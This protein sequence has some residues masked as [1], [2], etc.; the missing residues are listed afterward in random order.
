MSQSEPSVNLR[1]PRLEKRL[2]PGSLRR[3]TA[4][5]AGPGSGKT[6]L[7]KQCFD[8]RTAVWHTVTTA[9][10]TFSVLAR[11]VIRKLRLVIPGLSPDLVAAIE[12]ARGPDL[13]VDAGRPVAIVSTLAAD[14]D[15]HLDREVILVLDDLHELG[16]GDSAG[17]LDA[18]CRHGPRQIKV[19]TASRTALPFPV[20]R[21]RVAGEVDEI[22]S[23]DLL[24]TSEEVEEL[25]GIRM[26]TH[27]L[28]LGDEINRLTGGWPVA[29]VLAIEAATKN[30]ASLRR[31]LVE[32][33]PLFDYLAE[34]VIWAETPE[35]IEAMRDLALLPWVTP[36]LLDH[37]DIRLDLS[38]LSHSPV[39]VS[40]APDVPGAL[41]VSPLVKEYLLDHYPID[42]AS[43]GHL[44]TTAAEWYLVNGSFAEALEC[45]QGSDEPET[46]A[47]FLVE[48][49][50]SIVAAGLTRQIVETVSGLP[51]EVL[52]DDLLLLD[53]EAR[54]LLGDWE[55][56]A[57]RYRVLIPSE[58]EIPPRVAWRFG[59]LNHMRGNVGEALETY[60]RGR[61][62]TDDLPAEAALLGWQ[63]SAHWLRGERDQAKN[64]ADQ[65]LELGRLAND[66][67]PLATAHTVLAMVAALDGDR[68]SNDV[69]YLKALEYAEQGNDVVQT[70]RIRSNRASAFLEEGE[71]DAAIAELEIALRLADMTGFELWR[72]MSLLNRALINSV[73]GR[74]EEA[75][76]D[77]SEARVAFRQIGSRLESYP[78]AHLG[79]VYRLR[80]DT[81]RARVSYEE[82][83]ALAESQQDLQALVPAMSGLARLLAPD[84]PETAMQLAKQATEVDSVI[85]RV[86][87]LVAAGWAN[88]H[89]GHPETARALAEEAA[90]V[91]R[92]RR[93]MPG[94]GE[95]LEL[96]AATDPSMAREH[97]DE[98]KEVWTAL[99]APIAVARVEVEIAKQIG[100]TEGAFRATA[101]ADSLRRHG[102]RGLALLAGTSAEK[103][104]RGATPELA[105]KTLGG[106]DVVI[107]GQPVSRSAW[108]SKVAREVLWMLIAAR[109][110]PVN[111]EV[112]LDRLWP[113]E[114]TS[115]SSNRL[116]VALST[117]RKVLDP[118]GSHPGDHFLS[119][120]RDLVRLNVGRIDLDVEQFFEEARKGRVLLA[121]GN[122]ERG[123][124]YLAAAEERY[125]GE[126]LEEDPYAD[127][128][129]S[130]REEARSVYLTAA[131][132]L[133]GAA[134]D[135]GD[136]DR[137]A[138]LYMRMLERDAY[139]EPAHL[140]LVTA[141][142]RSGRH[143]TARRLYGNYV[144]RMAELDVEPE[145]LPD[146]SERPV[147]S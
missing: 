135:A 140:G 54:Q 85:G 31:S 30:A 107:D 43:R 98:A 35:S 41:V 110:R 117:I 147:H 70:I 56:A 132:T 71:F 81:A 76:A 123:L 33:S 142:Q 34:E 82:A 99:G 144:S 69:H 57:E 32:R 19:V 66:P 40:S 45:L 39:Y 68:A 116:S 3:L 92:S 55:G 94:L 102:A 50:G 86:Q 11:N 134:V 127:W 7:L 106:F 29:V 67:R 1:R 133:A 137:A 49:G 20:A 24:F 119:S 48:H 115:K 42:T 128:A 16:N 93:D 105:I 87:A 17:F 108:Q 51:E 101:A 145:P 65:A 14:L 83:I 60:R 121:Q 141:M 77:L 10:Q 96:S 84:D 120:D 113:S 143:G 88:H 26:P 37:L 15:D 5:T 61:R 13:S 126:F 97:L 2:E 114:D 9:D 139:S 52:T 80:G 146:S 91:A 78:V 89:A 72:A 112:L 109:G 47:R 36:E 21:L 122:R 138:R 38:S 25:I 63:A 12:G 27:A 103:M 90:G 59:F 4:L 131:S 22:G 44:L 62:G 28:D 118:A 23:D 100:G 53:A 75:A 125:F 73:R 130:L 18:L 8:T 95:A 79:E 46:A 136:H 111:R 74:L 104:G 58:G 6:T 64:L 124:A 129:I